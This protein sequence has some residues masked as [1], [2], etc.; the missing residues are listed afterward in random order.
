VRNRH[1]TPCLKNFPPL[2]CYNFDAH[3]W[4]LIFF[5]RNVTDKVGNQ[6][7]LYYMPP[8]ITCASALPGKTRKHE[9]HIF[10][11]VGLCYTQCI[12][13][14][15]SWK[16]KSSVMYL[17]ASNTTRGH[18]LPLPKLHPGPCNSVGMQPRRDRH[19]DTQTDTQ[20]RVS[21]VTTIHFAPSTTHAKCNYC[22]QYC[23]KRLH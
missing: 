23:V 8:Q 16:K 1:C 3:E 17:I 19:T 5:G 7:T 20:T 14:L 21:G 18:P 9:N 22:S 11:S 10:H 13:A 2:A 6:K 15:S 12:C 4:M